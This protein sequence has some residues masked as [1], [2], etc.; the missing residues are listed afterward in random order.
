MQQH[1]N[2]R[3]GLNLL[4]AVA[5]LLLI[6]AQLLAYQRLS[7]LQFLEK[8]YARLIA[9]H[10]PLTNST[11]TNRQAQCKY[12]VAHCKTTLDPSS[13]GATPYQCMMREAQKRS[14][15]CD[16]IED[17]WQARLS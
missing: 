5:T 13:F 4:F 10:H 8:S 6:I 2:K 17:W 3:T 16:D 11:L 15:Y 1:V 14:L 7:R 12:L 9:Q